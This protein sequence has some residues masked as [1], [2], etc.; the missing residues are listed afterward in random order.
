M[1]EESRNGMQVEGA[2]NT[3]ERLFRKWF[4]LLVTDTD[5]TLECIADSLMVPKIA[6]YQTDVNRRVVVFT[7]NSLF[8]PNEVAACHE[9]VHFLLVG[10]QR[11]LD[12]LQNELPESAHRLG[13]AI[14]RDVLEAAVDKVAR[15]FVRIGG[16]ASDG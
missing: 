2:M 7:Y 6:S 5:W 15:S 10:V 1:A 8:A 13:E 14:V 9:V 12:L 16:E 4:C 3:W 11:W